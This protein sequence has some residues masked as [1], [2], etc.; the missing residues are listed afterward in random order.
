MLQHE[1]V[2]HSC[3]LSSS[4]SWIMNHILFVHSPANRHLGG[5]RCFATVNQTAMGVHGEVSVWVHVFIAPNNR[6]RCE[7]AGSYGNS[8][9]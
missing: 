5:Y 8:S 6:S 7:I 3:S 2:L 9:V 1:L 4:S